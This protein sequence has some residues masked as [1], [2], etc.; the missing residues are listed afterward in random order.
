MSSEASLDVELSKKTPLLG[1]KLWVLIGISVGSIILLILG[2]LS[3]WITFWRRSKRTGDNK[4]TSHSQ[5]P[6]VSKEI[7]VDSIESHTVRDHPHSVYVS[8]N[9]KSVD[10]NSEKLIAHIGRSKS[11]DPD[12]LSQCSSVYQHE[13]ACSSQSGEEGS[14]GTI[15]NHQSSLSYSG[16]ATA[17]PLIGLPEASHLGWGHWFTLR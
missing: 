10:R 11:G 15:R 5:I 8:I 7:R 17:S 12:T 14:S 3:I 13:R 16:I 9:E 6:D 4:N 2:V 1:L